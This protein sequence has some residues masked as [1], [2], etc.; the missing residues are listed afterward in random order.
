MLTDAVITPSEYLAALNWRY[1]CKKFD[2]T[3]SIPNE[4]WETLEES[5]RLSPSSI[6]LQL[7]HFL[8]ID[9][10]DLRAKLREISWNQPQVT[11]ASRYVILC[12][13][14]DAEDTDVA[15]M[16][17]CIS[18]LRSPSPET[19]QGTQNF[20]LNYIHSLNPEHKAA[21]IE[22]QVHIAVGFLTSAAACLQV[23]SCIIGGMDRLAC[24]DI[25]G[26]TDSP[27]RSVVGVALGFRSRDDDYAGLAKVRYT[28]EHTI[29]YR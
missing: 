13:R 8:V 25:L 26:L 27:Y 16:I 3:R 29:E 7:W 24:D 18:S 6:G 4:T 28:R 5:L 9:T 12:A 17:E 21:W 1:A 10:P 15:S 2:P 23:D 20:M 22:A 14:R 11:D 19:L